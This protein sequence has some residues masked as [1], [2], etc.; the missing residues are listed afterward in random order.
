[1]RVIP[2]EEQQGASFFLHV[3]SIISEN[4]WGV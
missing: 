3:K 2:N 1:M 4:I